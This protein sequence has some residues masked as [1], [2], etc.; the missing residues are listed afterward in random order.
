MK[1]EYKFW[2]KIVKSTECNYFFSFEF[3]P[4]LFMRIYRT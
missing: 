2:M 4:D 1:L 3:L